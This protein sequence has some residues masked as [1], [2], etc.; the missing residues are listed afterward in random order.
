MAYDFTRILIVEDSAEIGDQLGATLTAAGF[1]T[2]LVG[3]NDAAFQELEGWQPS[4]VLVDLRNHDQGGRR[5]CATLAS[6]PNTA[7]PPVV[8]IGEA[9]NLMKRLPVT[10]SGLVPT[11]IDDERLVG[12]VRRVTGAMA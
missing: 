8:L 2:R 6:R 12:T 7:Y 10:A 3:S 4:A 11:P 1:S 9:P 5:F